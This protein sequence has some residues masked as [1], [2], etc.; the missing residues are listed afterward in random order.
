MAVNGI[1]AG[2]LYALL[3]VSWGVI[4]S[5]TRTFHI[6]H[7]LVFT[8]AAYAAV[9]VV[10]AWGLPL[11]AGILAA[12]VIGVITG[13]AIERFLY[14]SM[15]HLGAPQLNV[16]LASLGVLVAGESALLMAY[17]PNA[18]SLRGFPIKGISL[19]PVAFTTV[20]LLWIIGSWALIMLSLMWL[21]RSRWGLAIRAVASNPDL[22]YSFG[23]NP[24]RVFLAVYTL[25]SAL[26]AI[27]GVLFTL[28]NTASPFMGLPP[29][30]SAAIAV[31]LGGIGS[32]PGSA[33]GGI[34]LGLAENMGGLVLPGHWQGAIAF[35]VLFLVIVFVPSGLFGQR[36]R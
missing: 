6:A 26:A 9:V 28:R 1:I 34:L 17:G 35:I 23:I 12:V 15:R 10:T 18:Q 19:G 2:S 27:A 31:F 32:I 3:A 25:G 22:S 11:I 16:F 21:W 29:I 7:A 20:E 30:L 8:F 5:T 13:L 33:V 36:A 4:F 24:D 14:R